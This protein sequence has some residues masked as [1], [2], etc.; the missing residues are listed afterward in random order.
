MF[1]GPIL[2]ISNKPPCNT[3]LHALL[4]IELC[5]LILKDQLEVKAISQSQVTSLLILHLESPIGNLRTL[6]VA[7]PLDGN[8]TRSRDLEMHKMPQGLYFCRLQC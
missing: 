5:I 4:N 3:T 1:L 8:V 7:V 6:P 2:N